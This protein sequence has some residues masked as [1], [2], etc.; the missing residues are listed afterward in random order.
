MTATAV[1]YRGGGPPARPPSPTP[2][3]P[4]AGGF[5]PGAGGCAAAGLAGVAFARRGG[6]LAGTGEAA[7][8]RLYAVREPLPAVKPRLAALAAA[9][10]P[11][12][13]AGDFAQALMDLGAL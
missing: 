11:E 6:G 5:S 7:I 4:A 9:L 8:P 12:R 10:V 13:R 2:G 1:N 3:G